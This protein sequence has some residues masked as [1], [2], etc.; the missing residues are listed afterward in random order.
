MSVVPIRVK[1][2]FIGDGE[3]DSLVRLLQHVC[4]VAVKEL[5]HDDVAAFD[6]AHARA[7]VAAGEADRFG[8]PGAGGVDEHPRVHGSAVG[9]FHAPCPAFAPR[10]DECGARSDLGTMGARVERVGNHQSRVIDP[11]IRI[12]KAASRALERGEIGGVALFAARESAAG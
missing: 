4:V 9:Q 11:G 12:D 10:G 7:G 1:S 2:R 8:D 3:D 5:G 6:E